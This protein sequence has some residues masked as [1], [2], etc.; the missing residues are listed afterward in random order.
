MHTRNTLLFSNGEPWI[1]KNGDEEFDEP[2]GFYDE[3]EICELICTYLIYQINN[4]IPKE[5]VGLNRHNELGIFR[6]M[7]RP[8]AE[9]KK[10]G[11]YKDI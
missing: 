4:V 10:K 6:N 5:N 8:E 9:I 3:V 7:S 2:M 1:K 11:S